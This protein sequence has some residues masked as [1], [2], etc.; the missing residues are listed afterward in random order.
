MKRPA[1]CKAM[2]AELSNYLD[3][4]LDDSMCERIEQHL[5]RCAPCEAFLNSLE[6]TIDQ[7]RQL[8]TEKPRKALATKLYRELSAEYR[9]Q[10]GGEKL[11]Q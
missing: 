3:E 10:L 5:N 9:L 1:S 4:Q 11:A 2:F 8:A 7:L 6:S